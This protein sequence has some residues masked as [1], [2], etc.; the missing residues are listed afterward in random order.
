V[1]DEE[2]VI[3]TPADEVVE[4]PVVGTPETPS[5]ETPAAEGPKS[6]A[7]ALEEGLDQA[8]GPRHIT[9]KQDDKDSQDTRPR[10]ADGTFKAETPE[11]IAEREKLER[12]AKETPEEKAA[13][14]AKEAEEA[15]KV[16]H[17]NDPIDPAIKGRT[18]ERIK[19]L[20][21]TVK[22]QNVV[23]EQHKA[24]FSS[25]TETGAS[26]QEFAQMISY[27]RAIHSKDS[28]QLEVAYKTLQS[29]LRGLAVMLGKP[30]YEVNLLRDES[31]KD[32][33]DEIRAGTLTNQRAHEIALQRETQRMAKT[34]TE[35]TAREQQTA[36]QAKAAADAGVADLNALDAE[37]RARDGDAA[38]EA[39]YE[40]L[41]PML[42]PL[43]ERLDPKE[44]KGV[45][46]H[47]YNTLK[48]QAAPP[49]PP[50]P[51]PAPKP[52]PLRSKQ[53]AGAGTAVTAPKSALEAINA[54]LGM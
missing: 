5:A 28:A 2:V 43:F 31:N 30:L 18:A 53:P 32:L 22:A 10:N 26:P 3:E 8:K 16:D 12:Q 37:L 40:T 42:K 15:K 33:V 25:I 24:L 4:T 38:F 49:P 36:A 21:E 48:V 11:E 23:A 41:V 6:L 20:V 1:A 29:E 17:V 54:A 45:F 52:Q 35:S 13:R 39:K 9:P 50:P 14:E 34:R 51:P 19:A 44:W 47:H 46:M 7:D 27:M